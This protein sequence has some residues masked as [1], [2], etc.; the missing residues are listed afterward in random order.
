MCM[1]C[2][3]TRPQ[4]VRAAL[5]GL[6][7]SFVTNPHY[8]EGQQSSVRAGVE[9]L[10]RATMPFSWRLPTRPRLTPADIA[11]LLDAFAARGGN[12][13]VV[14]FFR[15]NRGNPVVFPARLIAEMRAA[16]KN[17]ASRAFIDNNPQLIEQYE[18]AARSLH[19]RHRH[20]GRPRVLRRTKSNRPPT[21]R[22]GGGSP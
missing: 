8:E 4:E 11:S 19:N 20:A 21:N 15:G 2:W 1:P 10:P 3:A 12:R 14:P 7:I 16:G 5:E 13:I 6:P 22:T 9:S 17:A 18:A